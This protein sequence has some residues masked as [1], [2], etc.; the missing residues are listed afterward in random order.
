MKYFTSLFLTL[1]VVFSSTAH[2]QKFGGFESY[3]S[4]ARS[5]LNTI[6]NQLGIQDSDNSIKVKVYEKINTAL[7]GHWY[8]YWIGM[9]DLASSQYQDG[10]EKGF[11]QVLLPTNESGIWILTLAKTPGVPQIILSMAQVRHGSQDAALSV[12]NERKNDSENYVVN[13]ESDNFAFIQEKGQVAF[14]MLNIGTGTASVV[15][16]TQFAIDL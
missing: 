14:S 15:Y 10:E 12:Y 4:G 5:L 8:S 1:A 13:N 11:I 9:N 2:A 7:E 6:V 3:D 16:V